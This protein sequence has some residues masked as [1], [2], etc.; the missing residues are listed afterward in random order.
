LSETDSLIPDSLAPNALTLDADAVEPIPPAALPPPPQ[1][2]VLELAVDPEDAAAVPRARC[3]AP[4]RAGRARS[5][6][7]ATVWHDTA[8]ATLAAAGLS[9]AEA[10]GMWRL[11]QMLPA[12]DHP[13]APGQPPPLLASGP[14]PDPAWPALAG[15][16]PLVAR[17]AFKGRNTALALIAGEGEMT[18]DLLQ[19]TARSVVAERPLARLVLRGPEPEVAA[20]ALALARELPASVPAASLA[21]EALACAAGAPPP[22]RH[23]GAPA[24]PPGITVA[25]AFAR[26]VGHLADVVLHWAPRAA[27]GEGGPEPVHQTRVA[28]RRLRSALSLFRRV[29]A[30]PLL[31][32]ARA[33]AKAL[34]AVLGPAR[35]WDVFVGGTGRAVAR[36]FADERSVARLL[37]S[38]ERRRV[39]AYAAL[40]AYVESAE[41]RRLGVLLAILAGGA[42]WQA[43]LEP[44]TRAML[45]APLDRFAARMLSRRLKAMVAAAGD[46]PA[47]LPDDALHAVRLHGKRLRYAAEFFMPLFPAKPARRFARRLAVLQERLGVLNDGAVARGLMGELGGPA[48]ERAFAVGIVLGFVAAESGSARARALRAWDRFRRQEPFW[49]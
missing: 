18:L 10:G 34:G 7:V 19:G 16:G 4:L 41:F 23:L 45:D 35:D 47:A 3:L 46:D 15:A 14:S 21:A 9:L 24:L 27:A 5:T 49:D 11:E 20:L 6:T 42:Q 13:W 2:F 39:A 1:D 36:A 28:V 17:A 37:A 43:A 48:G 38:A 31:D 8:E 33:G 22:A 26:V 29:A 25:D 40:A 30:S 12:A 44:E 32:E